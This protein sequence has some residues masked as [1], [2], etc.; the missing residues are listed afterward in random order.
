VNGC[1]EAGAP[2]LTGGLGILGQLVGEWAIACAGTTELTLSG[3]SG[4]VSSAAAGVVKSGCFVRMT[5]CDVSLSEEASTV[6][7]G[8]ARSGAMDERAALIHAGGVLRD[9]TIPNQTSG[10]VAAAMAPKA[11]GLFRLAVS[12]FARASHSTT[13]FSSVASLLGSAGQANYCAANGWLDAWAKGTAHEGVNA[14]SVQWGAWGGGHG[15][16]SD[17]PGVLARMERLGIGVLS[18]DVG[19]RWG[20]CFGIPPPVHPTSTK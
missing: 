4:R 1:V 20:S 16:A 10:S 19:L 14:T 5:R 8:D 7:S 11:S 17:S 6:L 3:R 18:P 15:M 12:S 2:L 13:L 9:A